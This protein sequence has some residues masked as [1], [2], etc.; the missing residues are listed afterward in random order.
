MMV[1]RDVGALYG[2]RPIPEHGPVALEV[3]GLTRRRTAR[4]PHAIELDRRLADAR[5]RARSSASPG[6][7]A[8]AAPR[9]RA[10]SSA[11]TR[12]TQGRS[13][14]TASRSRSQARSDAM[15][16][17]IG[18]VP[19]DRKKQ[20]LF[21]RLAIRTNMTI[22]AHDQISRWAGSSTSASED[23]LVDEF[24]APAQHPHG[25]PG[26]G[27]RAI[28]PAAISRRSCWRAGWRCGRRS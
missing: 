21:L 6:S 22:A 12:S 20:A 24:R 5:T 7:S 14:S 28:S 3:E 17:G 26:S 11:P 8:P 10:R 13:A 15:A 27:R 2:A 25:E 4:D 18:L 16:H 23:A 19:E 1:G 9:P